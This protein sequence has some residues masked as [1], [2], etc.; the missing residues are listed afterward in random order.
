MKTKAFEASILQLHGIQFTWLIEGHNGTVLMVT[1]GH[2]RLHYVVHTMYS[3][4]REDYS[5]Y[6]C[7]VREERAKCTCSTSMLFPM[8]EAVMSPLVLRNMEIQSLRVGNTWYVIEWL[9][10]IS[11]WRNKRHIHCLHHHVFTQHINQ[12]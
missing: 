1:G 9:W 7:T 12:T 3:L 4:R 8:L 10:S 5:T 11:S 2:Q 6:L